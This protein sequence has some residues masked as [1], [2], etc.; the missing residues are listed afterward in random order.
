MFSLETSIKALGLSKRATNTLLR[1]G[2]NT[3]QD[4]LVLSEFEMFEMRGMGITS[5]NEIRQLLK[6]I[7][8]DD[9]VIVNTCGLGKFWETIQKDDRNFRVLADYYNYGSKVTLQKLADK[10]G[11]S[12][13]R[14][15]QIISKGTKRIQD[16][17]INGA[18]SSDVVQALNEAADNR[19][20]I[21]TIGIHDDVFTAAGV[22][23][24]VSSF[25]PSIYRI[26]TSNGINGE[27]FI[28]ADDNL[29]KVLNILADELRY[30]SEPL[31]VSEVK[32]LYS[33]NDNI[34]MS[35]KGVIEKDGY[36]THEKNKLA[37][38]T[39]RN[40]NIERYLESIER[41][42]SI[43]EIVEHTIL[44]KNQV[45]GALCDKN[46]YVNVGRSVYDLVSR[47]YEDLS[48]ADLAINIITAENRAL[49]IDTISKYIRKYRTISDLN[50]SYALLNTPGIRRHE[51]Y[52]LLEGWSLDKI[53]TKS[54]GSYF[55]A[56]EDAVLE[57]INS[58]DELFDFEKI[59]KSLEKHAGTV[60]TNPNSIKATLA[61]LADKK[62]ITR[63]GGSRTGCYM[64]NE[65]VSDSNKIPDVSTLRAKVTLGTFLNANIGKQIE[66]RYKTKRVSSDKHWRVIGVRGQDA[67]YIYTNDLNNYG[68]RV[69]YLKD[70]VVEYREVSD[71]PLKKQIPDSKVEKSSPTM[72]I[73]DRLIVDKS[74]K[75]DELMEIFKVSSQGGMRKSNRTNSLVLIAR[76]REDNPYDDK[77]DGGHLEYTGMGLFG[78]QSVDYMQNKTLAESRSNNVTLYLF[79]S[80]MDNSYI[81]RG[82]V[83]LDG[84]PYYET[85]KDELGNERKVVK[86]SL[87]LVEN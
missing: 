21:H 23:H 78:D 22:A 48:V 62:L 32:E 9:A 43:A 80:Y 49:K 36:V 6:K 66:I 7:A 46:A 85:Q 67:R 8:S 81:Y 74:Y 59:S 13:E 73:A 11:V 76:H 4:L 40:R 31:L 38:G 83:S 35:I 25:K 75:N 12:R 64:R 56:L 16:A 17:F 57:I 50:I 15:R 79:E 63:V 42:A 45:R 29:G 24:L 61:R 72:S 2:V 82:I 44:N 26:Y 1:N 30:R 58:S 28:R 55:I 77:W 18:I 19:S 27:W 53:E 71:L 3:V 52:Y 10:Y 87:K 41:P 70:R 54:R 60:S 5:L 20:E 14:I 86:F 37:T 47:N 84:D 69:K 68:Y 51:D 65:G 39:D 34:L 33:I